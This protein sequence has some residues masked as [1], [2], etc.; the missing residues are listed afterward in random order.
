MT[1]HSFCLWQVLDSGGRS[2]TVRRIDEVAQRY[3]ECSR[4][5]RKKVDAS[6]HLRVLN[7]PEVGIARARHACKRVKRQSLHLTKSAYFIS[8]FDSECLCVHDF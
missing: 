3:A 7:L 6:V 1:I 2:T 5:A 4:K 8:Y